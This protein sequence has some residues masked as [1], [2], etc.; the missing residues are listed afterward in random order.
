METEGLVPSRGDV[1]KR[2]QGGPQ[3]PQVALAGPA[4]ETDRMELAVDFAYSVGI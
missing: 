2:K 3:R 4:V 1:S